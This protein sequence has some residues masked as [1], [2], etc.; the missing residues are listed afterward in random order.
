MKKPNLLTI[1]TKLPLFQKILILIFVFA[2]GWWAYDSFLKSN[3]N[4]WRKVSK[5][6][7]TLPLRYKIHGIDISHHNGNVNWT[8]VKKMRF[9]DEELKIEFA[10]MKAT[11]GIDHADKQFDRNWEEVK[12]VGIKRGAYHFYIPWRDPA[13][14]AKSFINS[15]KLEK[16]DFAPVLDIEKNSLKS[17]EKIVNEIGIW[18]DLVE[19]HYGKKPIIYTNPNFY[20]K[21]IKGNFEGYPLWIAVY[22]QEKVKGYGRSLW[23]WQHSMDGWAEG[24]KGNVDYN[25]FLGTKAEMNDLCL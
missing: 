23:F 5:I 24:V 3:P 8:R 18:L 7:I 1:F 9:T 21:F 6:G 20:N 19:K 11:E 25:V 10:F 12:K 13:S 4:G 16:G 17:N 2:L 14:Q 15:V 22:S